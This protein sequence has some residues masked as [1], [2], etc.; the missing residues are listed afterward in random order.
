MFAFDPTGFKLVSGCVDNTV[1]LWDVLSGREIQILEGHTGTVTNVCFSA[2][3]Q[4]IASKGK[5]RDST[6]RLWHAK[7]GLLVAI[8]PEPAND[9]LWSGLAFNPSGSLLATVG[10]DPEP[11]ASNDFNFET[12][13]RSHVIHIWELDLSILLGQLAKEPMVR[14]TSVSTI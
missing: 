7:T 1:R 13:G 11:Y 9:T 14:Y 12:S 5:D 3:G 2:N 6:I 4:L 10:S 8:F